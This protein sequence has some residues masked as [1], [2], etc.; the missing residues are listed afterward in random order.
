VLNPFDE[1]LPDSRAQA[2]AQALMAELPAL[3]EG[4]M[5][6][7]LVATSGEVLRAFSA[8]VDAPGFSPH[9]FDARARAE[10]EPAADLAVK[11][12]TARLP[13]LDEREAAVR[14]IETERAALRAVHLE[15]RK[16]RHQQPRTPELDDESRADGRARKD[17]EQRAEARLAAF[18]PVTR[19]YQAVERLRRIVSREAMRRIHDTYVLRNA[20]GEETTLRALFAPAEPPWGAGECAAVKLLSDALRRGLEPLALAEFWWGPPPAGGGRVHGTFYPACRTKCGPVLPFLMRGLVVTPRRPWTPRP[21][22]PLEILFEDAW[23][24]VVAKPAG[25]LSVPGKNETD[26]VLQRLR[27]R[28]PNATLVHRLDLDTSGV[29]LA[30]LDGDTHRALQRQFLSRTVE[31]R[32]VACLE[33]EVAGDAGTVSLPLRVDLEQR[34]R[35]MVCFTH[36]KKAVTDWRVLERAE[37]RTWVELFPRTGRTHQLRVHAAHASGLKAPIVGDRLYGKDGARLMLHAQSLTFTH[38]A[39]GE[40]VTFHSAMPL[41][42]A[43]TASSP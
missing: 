2:A 9:V 39:T 37:G 33:G 1:Q 3:D 30:A 34:P 15:R 32:Y 11:A 23:L 4:K 42:T 40:R 43:P 38:P 17:F 27:V 25:L 22:A 21:L 24:A 8:G 36:G 41:S 26:S 6:G 20:R 35:Q 13:S 31:K 28:H 19:R 14:E 7:V 29:L 16:A 10:I 18:V 5:Y 12:L